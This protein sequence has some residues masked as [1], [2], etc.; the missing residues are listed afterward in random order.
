MAQQQIVLSSAEEAAAMSALGG[1][2]VTR[3]PDG[4]YV[5]SVNAASDVKAYRERLAQFTK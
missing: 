1:H 4:T 2:Q 5:T 3:Q